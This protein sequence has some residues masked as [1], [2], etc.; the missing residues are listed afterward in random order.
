MKTGAILRTLFL[1]CASAAMR[2]S[3]VAGTMSREEFVAAA[4]SMAD[5]QLAQLANKKPDIDWVPA[6]MWAGIADL[7]HLSSK[8]TYSK[9]IDQLG[10]QVHWTP[11]L[12]PA[13][14][15]HADDL[16]IC[17]TFLDACATQN[18]PAKLAP[19]Q[20]R[21]NAVSN[22]IEHKEPPYV[23]GAK[24]AQLTWWWCD[25]LF[26]APAGHAR[27]SAITKDRKYLD[28]MEK[29]W[30]RTAGL[31]YDK[32]E[33]LFYRDSTFLGTR[34]KNG[35]KVFWSR[36]NGWV[37]AGIARTLVYMPRDYPSRP[38]YEALFKD[39]A[40][41][42]ASLQQPDGTWHASLLDAGEFPYS[43][44][45]GTALDCFALA[46][47]IDNGLLDRAT[48]LPIAAKAWAAL[49]AARRPDGLLGYV[50]GVG[51]APGPAT[52]NGT[53]PYATGAFIM[54]ACELSRLAPITVP[55]PPLLTS[56]PART[57]AGVTSRPYGQCSE[58]EVYLHILTNANGLKAG[59]MDYG[60]TVVNVVTPD[61]RGKFAD[62]AIGFDSPA[63]YAGAKLNFGTMG[64]YINRIGH[65][66]I[67]LDGKVYP[68]TKNNGPNTMHGGKLGFNRHLWKARVL[69]N[70][71]P[72]IRFSRLS[73]DGEE[74]FPG[75]LQVSVT[76]TLANDNHL[77]VHYE[78]VTDKPTVVNLSN[79]TLFALSGPGNGTVLDNIATINADAFTPVDATSIPTG[80]IRKVEGTPWDLRKPT[81]LGTH[82]NAFGNKPPG[83][84]INYVLNRDAAAPLTKAGEVYDPKSG[85][86]LEVLTDQPGAQ[87]YTGNLFDGTLTGK[88]GIKY[89][90]YCAFSIEAQHFPDSPNHPD[91]PS[92]ILRPGKTY[93]A[94]IEYI[95]GVR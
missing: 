24:G 8:S 48:Y 38:R 30:W 20:S 17:Q 54:A 76:F 52:A 67:T 44:S 31:L 83:Y 14:P 29:E 81:V 87:F 23:P 94:T 32:E 68:L 45:S 1:L 62:I 12:R 7:S 93:Q 4:E 66:Q 42:L 95:F 13:F 70:D 19:S 89:T 51:K 84:D 34:T 28:A 65:G 55:S 78:A 37:F 33:H 26:M 2:A 85:R 46:W 77:R 5:V 18:D 59:I 64:R 27:L 60:A 58:G 15:N 92:T 57:P 22:F 41:K 39:M 71:P 6:V 80:E 35:K 69:G 86:D 90:Q 40:A 79:H 36:G 49:M 75:N 43:E 53:Q 3:A 82:I 9:A 91:F 25:A 56:G 73:P 50:Q 11:L 47:G 61:R 10:Q 72:S 74:G 63:G 16:C 21:I 88:G